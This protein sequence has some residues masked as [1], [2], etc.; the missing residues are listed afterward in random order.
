MTRSWTLL[1][2]PDQSG[3]YDVLQREPLLVDRYDARLQPGHRQQV[4]HQ[5]RQTVGL[6]VDLAQ[7]F[8]AEWARL[9]PSP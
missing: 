4:L 1:A 8:P 9:A 6:V 2:Q 5:P 7:Q 3:A